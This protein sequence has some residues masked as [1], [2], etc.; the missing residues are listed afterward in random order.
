M[1]R[2]RQPGFRRRRGS[3]V[4]EFAFIILVF[5]FLVLG[6]LEIG[7][8]IMVRQ[9]LDDA[10]RRACRKG[11]Q[12][13]VST[14]TI[15]GDASDALSEDAGLSASANVVV[16][17]NG[18]P[19]TDASTAQRG[20]AIAVQVTVPASSVYWSSYLYLRGYTLQSQ[21]VVMMRQQ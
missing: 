17:V 16:A 11:I 9:A 3:I 8:G 15:K 4:V 2:S 21:N 6:G 10:A 13:A 20:D 1:K 19:N 7:R 14:A 12:G 5:A 18:N